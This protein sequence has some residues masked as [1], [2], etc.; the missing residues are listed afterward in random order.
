MEE[1]VLFIQVWGIP[2]H[3]SVKMTYFKLVDKIEKLEIWRDRLDNVPEV[4]ITE[5]RLF[6]VN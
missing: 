3:T 5:N 2:Q 1:L 6:Q 4:W